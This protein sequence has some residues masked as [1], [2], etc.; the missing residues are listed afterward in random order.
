[1]SNLQMRV[2]FSSYH[3]WAAEHFMGLASD[4]EAAHQGQSKF[5]IKHR[6]YVTGAVF[7]SVAFL[8]AAINE[9]FKDAADKH[10]SYVGSLGGVVLS[11]LADKWEQTEGRNKHVYILKKYQFALKFAQQPIFIK[12]E[13]PYK[14]VG[15][16]IR[17]RNEL[18][19]YKPETLGGTDIH[20]LQVELENKFPINAIMVNSAS[21]FFPDKCLG[22]GCVK[23][24]LTSSRNFTD[25]FFK[26]LGVIP[27][28][29]R[30]NFT[31]DE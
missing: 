5:N 24:A 2:Y 3:L 19:H 8:E 30:A 6:T 1:M 4:I 22:Y 14:D 23:W 31:M 26:K 18:V 16:L 21:P 29:K 7:A 13:P 12:N 11:E 25:E 15:L 20:G 9:L 17:L 10:E 28:Y 27:S